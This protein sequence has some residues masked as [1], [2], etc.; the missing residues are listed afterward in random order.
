ME[1]L[2]YILLLFIVIF[3]L[4]TV[5]VLIAFWNIKVFTVICSIYVLLTVFIIYKSIQK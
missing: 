1:K 4:A 2:F 3:T 5:G